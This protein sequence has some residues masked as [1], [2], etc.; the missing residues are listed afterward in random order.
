MVKQGGTRPGGRSRRVQQAVFTAMEHLLAET[1][2]ELPPLAAVAARAG[3]NP[4]SLY[5]RWRDARTLAGAVAVARLMRELPVPDTGSLRGD[6]I[7][8]A[9]SAALSLT[10]PGDIALLRILTATPRPDATVTD[11]RDLPIGPRV[12][13]L[14]A[15]LARANARGE[16]V[17]GILDVLEIVLAPIY[18]RAFF[19]GP[20]ESAD[21]IERLV[22][23]LL[24]EKKAVLF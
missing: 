9:A 17:P 1:P 18:L 16:A 21:G 11:L 20:F 13:E 5:R 10:T 4:T 22:E 3:V 19:I 2:G 8:W 6:L 12:A 24:G 7:G 23:R 14:Q 15:M